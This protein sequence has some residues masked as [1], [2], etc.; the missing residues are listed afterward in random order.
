MPPPR[1]PRKLVVLGL[2]AL[3]LVIVPAAGTVSSLTPKCFGVSATKVLTIRDHIFRGGP[4]RDVVVGSAADDSIFG[5]G[6]DDLI[7]GRGGDDLIAGDDFGE[8][9]NDRIDGGSGI[10]T[11]VGGAG[12]DFLEGGRGADG[13]QGG[14]GDDR[15]DGGAGIAPAGIDY[16]SYVDSGGPVTVDLATRRATGEGSD[17]LSRLDIVDGSP[18]DDVLKGDSSINFFD[19]E[20]G[21]DVIDGRGGDDMA[22][23]DSAVSANLA[24]GAATGTGSGSDVLQQLEGL[25]GSKQNDVLTGNDGANYLAGGPGNDTIAGGSGE[26][27]AFG[28]QGDDNLDG[29]GGEDV[30]GGDAGNDTLSGGTGVQDT[31]SY[32]GSK[33]GV[34]V[35]LA[36]GLA[37]GQGADKLS[38]FQNVSGS[39]RGDSIVGDAAANGLSGNAGNDRI[40]AGAGADFL[41][42][43]AG[44]NRLKGGLGVDYC[45]EGTGAKK[46]EIRGLPRIP[47][48]PAIPPVKAASLRADSELPAE[49][50]AG[51]ESDRAKA[52]LRSLPAKERA[53]V[54]RFRSRLGFVLKAL[55]PERWAAAGSTAGYNYVGEPSCFPAQKPY[56]TKIAPPERVEPIGSAPQR[57]WWQATLYRQ[58]P[59][60]KKWRQYRRTHWA[61]ASIAGIGIPGAP[62]WQNARRTT[63]VRS[64]SEQVPPGK[65]VWKGEI[66]W[67]R[68]RSSIFRAIEPHIVYTPRVEHAKLCK[69]F[70]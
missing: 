68:T 52:Y 10:D 49:E 44:S 55:T 5:A 20:R 31:V 16:V 37:T 66:Y 36:T 67:E 63:F 8:A 27:R 4:G 39:Q 11:I 54:G 19:G 62:I 26:D 30:V 45:L 34:R 50:I 51:L 56:Q 41:G 43:D 57:A 15:I 65:Y 1:F 17:T 32:L 38:D 13:L 22:L 46:C 6:G 40:T 59:R 2:A 33:Q 35:N 60:T 18:F 9:G 47:G 61:T 21:N 70:G 53:A 42:G 69:F 23:F 48:A 3:P 28:D 7:C 64:F 24:T 14:P 25:I 29:G 12:N 58:N